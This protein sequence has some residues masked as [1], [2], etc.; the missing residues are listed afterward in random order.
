VFLMYLASYDPFPLLFLNLVL[1]F[2]DP[3][4]TGYRPLQKQRV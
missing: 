3:V 4:R 1:D 2:G